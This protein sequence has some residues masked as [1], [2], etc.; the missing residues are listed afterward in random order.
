MKL[1]QLKNIIEGELRKLSTN[2]TKGCKGCGSGK[3]LTTE[4]M[5]NLVPAGGQ[6]RFNEGPQAWTGYCIAFGGRMCRDQ[7]DSNDQTCAG[8]MC[9]CFKPADASNVRPGGI[10]DMPIGP[11]MG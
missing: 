8:S 7:C 9:T 6:Q 2:K 3:Q 10:S 11:D 5:A 4:Q 1:S